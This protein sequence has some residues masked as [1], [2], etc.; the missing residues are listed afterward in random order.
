MP[1]NES[2]VGYLHRVRTG[3]VAQPERSLVS[4]REGSGAGAS[5]LRE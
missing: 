1:L 3:A 2:S 5:D 4:V